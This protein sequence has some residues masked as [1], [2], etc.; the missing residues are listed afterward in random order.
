MKGSKR[1]LLLLLPALLVGAI[2][3]VLY[4]QST[5]TTEVVVAKKL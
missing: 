1:L 5:G 4:N 3:Y 2:V